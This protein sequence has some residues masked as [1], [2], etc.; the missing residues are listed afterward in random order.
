MKEDRLYEMAEAEFNHKKAEELTKEY[1]INGRE[2]TPD[3]FE[4]YERIMK[5]NRLNNIR[6][7][8]EEQQEVVGYIEGNN[9]FLYKGY[10][11]VKDGKEVHIVIPE[12][13]AIERE[14]KA[15]ELQELDKEMIEIYRIS[16][17][18]LKNRGMLCES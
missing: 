10:A 3:T 6:I 2:V 4:C 17:R 11:A 9:I 18:Y 12:H 15:C 8:N 16:K 13:K 14:Y 1:F 7:Y 5:E